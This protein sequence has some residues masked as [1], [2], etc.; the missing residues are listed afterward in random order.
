MQLLWA[1]IAQRYPVDGRRVCIESI[2]VPSKE[3]RLFEI[4]APLSR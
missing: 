1:R 3:Q 2:Y 4:T